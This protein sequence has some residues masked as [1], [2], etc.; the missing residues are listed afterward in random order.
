MHLDWWIW[1]ACWSGW[2]HIV[3][4][5]KD[6]DELVVSQCGL[7]VINGRTGIQGFCYFQYCICVCL[8]L[9]LSFFSVLVFF[10]KV[11]NFW[12]DQLLVISNEICN[13][14]P[15]MPDCWKSAVHSLFLGACIFIL[16]YEISFDWVGTANKT[17][18][19]CCLRLLFSNSSF[20]RFCVVFKCCNF[21]CLLLDY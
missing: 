1:V 21:Q 12:L 18:T 3:S 16:K 7:V 14:C 20:P 15:N 10:I 9:E 5:E 11:N 2:Y 4:V 6:V 19:R 8:I 13:C 17:S